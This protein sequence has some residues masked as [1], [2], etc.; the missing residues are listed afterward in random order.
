M[1]LGNQFGY[2]FFPSEAVMIG[3]HMVVLVNLTKRFRHPSVHGQQK[4]Q[5]RASPNT[6]PYMSAMLDYGQTI[7][8]IPLRNGELGRNRVRTA[9]PPSMQ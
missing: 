1:G 8:S 9:K 6:T 2:H 4:R 7:V 3:G 5:S